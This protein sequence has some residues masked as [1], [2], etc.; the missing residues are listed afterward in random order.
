[1]VDGGVVESGGGA[2]RALMPVGDT[3]FAG[4]DIGLMVLRPSSSESRWVRASVA[5]SGTMLGRR[6]RSLARSDSVLAVATDDAVML[7]DLDTRTVVQSPGAIDARDIAP[8]NAVAIDDR[9]LW[10]AGQR[11]V[12]HVDRTT[13]VTRSFPPAGRLGEAVHDVAVQGEVVWLAT[14]SGVVRVRASLVR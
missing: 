14:S 3:L 10:I 7:V 5:G 8:L 4:T 9:S 2:V 1:M 6:I 13:G 12:V 11:G